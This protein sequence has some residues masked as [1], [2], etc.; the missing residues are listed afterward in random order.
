MPEAEDDDEVDGRDDDDEAEH[1]QDLDESPT[2]VGRQLPALAGQQAQRD[3]HRGAGR[4]RTQRSWPS[5]EE[6]QDRRHQGDGRR[7]S[8]ADPEPLHAL[9]RGADAT[10]M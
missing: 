2:G 10:P 1:R 4:H 8:D 7:Q 3:Q 5:D 6:M 9:A